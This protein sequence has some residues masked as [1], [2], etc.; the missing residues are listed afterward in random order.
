[1][2]AASPRS[3]GSSDRLSFVS[4]KD[5]LRTDVRAYAELSARLAQPSADRDVLLAEHGTSE[6]EWDEIDD[7][8]Q[9]RLSEAVDAIGDSDVVPPL[10]NEHAEAFAK[11]QAMYVNANAP[12]EFEAFIALTLEIQRGQEVQHVLKRNGT[13]LHEYLRAQRFWLT[14]M[15][16]DP[17]MQARFHHAMHRKK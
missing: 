8:W 5:L 3:A 11:A 13:D 17:A 9:A 6:D 7:V 1:M 15:M 10:V 12:M 14:R 16:E 4:P 2:R